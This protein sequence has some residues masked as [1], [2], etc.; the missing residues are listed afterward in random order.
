MKIRTAPYLQQAALWPQEGQHILAQYDENS[1]VVYQAYRRAIGEYALRHGRL[2]GPDFSLQRMSWIKPNFLWMMY[3]SGWGQKEG[4]E[5]VLGLR[6]SRVFFDAVLQAAVPSTW[7]PERYATAE[8]WQAAV[9]QSEVRL[10]WDPDHTPSGR[11]HLRRAVQLGLRGATLAAFAGEQLLDVIDMRDLVATQRD[12]AFDDS[13]LLQTPVEQVYLPA[14][15]GL[16]AQR[17]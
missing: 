9:A 3:R 16:A 8:A 10:Q 15:L 11:K 13:A 5:V 6:I 12:V 4:Q 14:G 1:V 17:R 2:D 7:S